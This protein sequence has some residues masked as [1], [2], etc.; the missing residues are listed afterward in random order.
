MSNIF[1]RLDVDYRDEQTVVINDTHVLSTS[2][3][4]ALSVLTSTTL[5]K[6]D[7]ED[8]LKGFDD[9]APQD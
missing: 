5:T 6:Q 4:A 1:E 3:S 9:N 2:A 8:L 7:V